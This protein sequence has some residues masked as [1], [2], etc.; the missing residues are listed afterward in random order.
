MAK[1]VLMFG[2][3]V[4]ALGPVLDWHAFVQSWKASSD[5]HST[6]GG[7]CLPDTLTT[8]LTMAWHERALPTWSIVCFVHCVNSAK[9]K[10]PLLVCGWQVI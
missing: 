1:I 6:H 9:L 4:S 2:A 8:T 3:K 10:T 5:E 7:S